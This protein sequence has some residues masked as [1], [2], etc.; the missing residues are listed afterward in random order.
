MVET[1]VEK[2]PIVS[3]QQ[4]VA[5]A[6]AS[7]GRAAWDFDRR[8][9][10]F[11]ATDG[12]KLLYGGDPEA[13]FGLDQFHAATHPDDR[14]LWKELLEDGFLPPSEHVQYRILGI[15]GGLR[16]LE[17]KIGVGPG[18]ASY[19]GIVKDITQER[20]TAN[21]LAASE[22]RLRFAIEAGR[23]AV[24]EV[25]MATG[26]LTNS[27]ELN[28]LLGLPI[29]ATPSLQDA[30]KLYAP[31]EIERLEREG[32]TYEKVLE[33][34]HPG[35]QRVRSD[36]GVPSSDRTQI[37]TE[38]ALITPDGTRKQLLLRAQHAP[39]LDGLGQR[40]TGVLVD[41]TDRKLS[42]D[43]MALVARELQHRVKN[44]LAVVSTIAVQTFRQ[45]VDTALAREAFAGR[46]KALDVALDS[47]LR[48]TTSTVTLREIVEQIVAPYRMHHPE[49]FL[50]DGPLVMLAGRRTTAIGMAIHELCTNAL[51]YGALSVENGN[52]TV[53]W[54]VND[55][56]LRLVW[57]ESGGPIVIPPTSTGFG[58]KLLRSLM[59]DG[60]TEVTYDE[61][62]VRCKIELPLDSVP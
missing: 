11:L 18:A 9:G 51:K 45:G 25:D 16:W 2:S 37:Q 59:H 43:R 58:T 3:A 56:T 62:G 8:T 50:V 61:S 46:V 17:S 15:G 12:L 29:D 4:R 30:R 14:P 53:K 28:L 49:R 40:V 57:S 36:W 22:E 19:T 7:A 55:E 38:F 23:M 10:E 60:K 21:A 35:V 33:R 5:E 20:R 1:V 47:V 44:L 26:K 54:E 34:T 13:P 6:L 42:E 52:V 27:P 32:V 31:G 41:I 48:T 39:S 24:W